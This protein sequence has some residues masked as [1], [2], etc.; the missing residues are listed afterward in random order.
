MKKH[1]EYFIW[2]PMEILHL[3]QPIIYCGI[4]VRVYETHRE[5]SLMLDYHSMLVI[6]EH[7]A[8]FAICFENSDQIV[9]EIRR[10]QDS[11]LKTAY[12]SHF[13]D[14]MIS[15]HHAVN[16]LCEQLLSLLNLLDNFQLD[17]LPR[18]WNHNLVNWR[19]VKPVKK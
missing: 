15:Y 2:T 1:I 7:V 4:A 14:L 13:H 5:L 10:V 9:E 11:L 18:N 3:E 12:A 6:D 17:A 19:T 16:Q 8:D